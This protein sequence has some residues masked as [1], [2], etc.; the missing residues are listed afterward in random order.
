MTNPFSKESEEIER[1]YIPP[2]YSEAKDSED[3]DEDDIDDDDIDLD[4]ID[5]EDPA[6]EEEILEIRETLPETSED[7]LPFSTSE[8]DKP[9]PQS[10]FSP[11]PFQRPQPSFGGQQQRPQ[12]STWN[13]QSGNLSWSGQQTPWGSQQSQPS[14]APKNNGVSSGWG[15]TNNWGAKPSTPIGQTLSLDR[16]KKVILCDVL[17]CIICTQEGP[18]RTGLIPRDIWDVILRLDVWNSFRRFSYLERIYP[19][20][21]KDL[22]NSDQESW[23]ILLDYIARSLA[24]FLRIPPQ[25]VQIV[26]QNFIAQP[27]IDMVSGIVKGIPKE[28]IVYIGTQSGLVGQ[29]S[30]DLDTAT[31]LE[32][33]YIDLQN[34]LLQYS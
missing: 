5:D 6:E 19:M 4:D 18:Q 7:D 16:T 33:E 30:I 2:D 20:I 21:P 10:T 26:T 15:T 13:N 3:D 27:K 12:M 14:W 17:D 8:E 9:K 22:I 34:F 24:R 11:P 1:S 25:S 23:V 32:V 28:E 31:V 29:S